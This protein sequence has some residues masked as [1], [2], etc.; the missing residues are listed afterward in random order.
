MLRSVPWLLSILCVIGVNAVASLW[1]WTIHGFWNFAVVW[2]VHYFPT[3][4]QA[5]QLETITSFDFLGMTVCLAGW[6]GFC[7]SSL[8]VISSCL[9]VEHVF[10]SSLMV[11]R[12]LA[13]SVL[14][15]VFCRDKQFHKPF[16]K[17]K[18]A[19]LAVNFNVRILPAKRILVSGWG[20]W[21][22]VS[23]KFCPPSAP[24]SCWQRAEDC[25]VMFSD[26]KAHFGH[27]Y[28]IRQN[29]S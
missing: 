24:T 9:C 7:F 2:L 12:F 23:G 18:S 22:L 5:F 21:G 10:S 25:S 3:R 29:K 15:A 20:K 14:V 8:G 4:G 28:L 19:Y 17:C 16:T 27:W 13:Q 26:K 11:H 1:F 6:I